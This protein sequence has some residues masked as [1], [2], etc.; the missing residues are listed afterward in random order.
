L[1]AAQDQKGINPAIR[2]VKITKGAKGGGTGN[3]GVRSDVKTDDLLVKHGSKVYTAEAKTMSI[4]GIATAIKGGT[5]Y[6]Q[7]Y[8]LSK[9]GNWRFHIRTHLLKEDGQI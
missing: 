1:P 4:A 6:E 8:K 2:L 9:D 7:A 5:T 3:A